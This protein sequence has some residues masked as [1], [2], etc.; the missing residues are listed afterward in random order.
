M[1]NDDATKIFLAMSNLSLISTFCIIN[2]YNI[3]NYQI[4][5]SDQDGND[6]KSNN[7]TK[8]LLNKLDI[9]K[10]KLIYVD[11]DSNYRLISFLKNRTKIKKNIKTNKNYNLI[12]CT[13]Y[14]FLFY[15][16]KSLT[17]QKEYSL[18]D[19]GITNWI[20]TV[21]RFVLLKSFLL[22]LLNFK[23]IKIPKKRIYGNKD[24]RCYY[25]FIEK[26]Y[27]NPINEN[28]KFISIKNQYRRLI[29][30]NNLN[31]INGDK[32]YFIVLL[33]LAKNIHYK[34]GI[35]V[36]LEETITYIKK[37]YK[38]S[39][40]LIIKLHPGYTVSKKDISKRVKDKI[41]FINNNLPIEFYD[42]SNV[43]ILL[44]PINSSLFL[45]R[46][47]NLIKKSKIFYYDIIQKDIVLKT[48]IAK[49]LSI[50]LAKIADT[51]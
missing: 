39:F 23:L 24:I 18:M 11:K 46:D 48:K 7:N 44:S 37:K 35:C 38:K 14:G 33:I 30:L 6:N 2:K 22:S 1:K 25:G 12:T 34:K 31:L 21:D 26:I 16:I 28:L 40:K 42:F 45:I 3:T 50:K 27:N 19:E 9:D 4:I 43:D 15:F 20:D 51:Y 13:N 36:M 8:F 41:L 29:N 47:L 5:I 17:N 10:K 49:S 32:N